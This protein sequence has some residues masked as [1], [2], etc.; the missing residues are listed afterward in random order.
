[1]DVSADALQ[2]TY[3]LE[4]GHEILGASPHEATNVGWVLSSFPSCRFPARYASV[5]DMSAWFLKATQPLSK[6]VGSTDLCLKKDRKSESIPLP[7]PCQTPIHWS[8]LVLQVPLP[9]W[10]AAALGSPTRHHRHRG[11]GTR[12]VGLCSLDE[13]T[14][15]YRPVDLW[16]KKSEAKAD[17]SAFQSF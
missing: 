10:A 7:V 12:R 11:L 17:R 3:R 14:V 4:A 13:L 9:A 15:S 6:R 16:S 2:A 5:R 8:L 1:M